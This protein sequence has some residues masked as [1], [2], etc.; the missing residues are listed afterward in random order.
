VVL[1]EPVAV[2]AKLF[3]ASRERQRFLDRAARAKAAD[4]RRLVEHGQLHLSLQPDGEKGCRFNAPGRGVTSVV[5]GA[6][7]K[8][9]GMGRLA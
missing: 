5:G 7:Q 2:V 1:G 3:H 6:R 4:D 9:S 8:P